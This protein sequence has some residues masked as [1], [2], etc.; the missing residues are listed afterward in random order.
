MRLND[1]YILL[2]RSNASYLTNVVNGDVYQLNDV[3]EDVFRLCNYTRDIDE[4][5]DQI[6]QNYKDC[7]DDYGICDLKSFILEMIAM[8]IIVE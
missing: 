7:P 4:L 2:K 3:S 1:D 6:Y 8:G 5:A